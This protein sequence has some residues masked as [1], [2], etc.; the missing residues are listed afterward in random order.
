MRNLLL[1]YSLNDAEQ[2][3]KSPLKRTAKLESLQ[4]PNKELYNSVHPPS[5][6]DL[7]LYL[8]I[9]STLVASYIASTAEGV[10]CNLDSLRENYEGLK[11]HISLMSTPSS[12]N[13]LSVRNKLHLRQIGKLLRIL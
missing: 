7:D 11:R 6:E 5:K 13:K 4:T 2:H 12:S 8:L 1:K 9:L 10:E 3:S